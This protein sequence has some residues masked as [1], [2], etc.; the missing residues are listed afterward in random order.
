V[1]TNDFNRRIN[2]YP[3]DAQI[4]SVCPIDN[5]KK[6]ERELIWKFK[7]EFDFISDSG[8]EYLEG[9]ERDIILVFNHNCSDHLPNWDEEIDMPYH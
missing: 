8:N 4:T 3:L 1:R 9:N 2:E 6:C 7:F 5:E